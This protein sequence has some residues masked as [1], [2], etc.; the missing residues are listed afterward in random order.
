MTRGRP[1]QPLT[2]TDDVRQQL[3]TMANSRSLPHSLETK[4]ANATHWTCRSIAKKTI[5]QKL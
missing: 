5:C 1:L 4:P 3:K 2:I